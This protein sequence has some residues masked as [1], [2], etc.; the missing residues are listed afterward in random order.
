MSRS[1][2]AIDGLINLLLLRITVHS[3]EQSSPYLRPLKHLRPPSYPEKDAYARLL[4]VPAAT[5]RAI[6]D[7]PNDGYLDDYSAEGYPSWNRKSTGNGVSLAMFYTSK[8]S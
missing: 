3:T 2:T 5:P 1:H 6:H 8:V 7:F 4:P